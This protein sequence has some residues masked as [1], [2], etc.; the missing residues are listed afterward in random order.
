ME[1]IPMKLL[2]VTQTVDKDDLYLGFFHRWIEEFAPRYEKVTVVALGTGSYQLPSNVSVYS[3]GKEQGKSSRLVYA[4]RFLRLVWRLR[5]DYDAVLVHMNQE[6]IVIAGW[7]WKLLGK[8]I[9][10]WRN[11][12]A[13]SLLTDIAAMFC[14][15]VFCTSKFSYTAKY[16][17]TVLMPV[18]VDT[19]RFKPQGTQ[20][21]KSILWSSRFAPSK[22]PD[23]LVEALGSLSTMAVEYTASFYGTPLPKDI[24]YRDRVIS[25]AEELHIPAKFYDGLPNTEQP[26]IMGAHEVFVN[27]GESGMYDKMLFEAAACGCYVLGCSADWVELVGKEFEAPVE[28]AALAR[29]L[30]GALT[31]ESSEKAIRLQK[32]TTA[33]EAHSLS[34]LSERLAT[35][36]NAYA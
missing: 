16:K 17:K 10:L 23:L 15:K 24:P 9:Y 20:L 34:K 6:Y 7:L 5:K 27:L 28:P 25:H 3:L 36:F 12:Y 33:V 13:G 11:H 1:G 2:I 29:V 18:G 22:H 8:H 32:L 30:A 14:T 21:P 31:L 35:E 4:W 19:A 26:R